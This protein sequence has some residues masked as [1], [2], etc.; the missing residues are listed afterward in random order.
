MQVFT[1]KLIACPSVKYVLNLQVK[2]DVALD[3]G[4]FVGKHIGKIFS[5]GGYQV[6]TH[7]RRDFEPILCILGFLAVA[8]K[9]D[10]SDFLLGYFYHGS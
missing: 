2:H 7:H 4:S 9:L 1:C 8:W 5:V 3:A 10:G 6:C